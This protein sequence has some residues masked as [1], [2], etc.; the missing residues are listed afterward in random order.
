MRWFLNLIIAVS[1]FWS[2]DEQFGIGNDDT[3]QKNI[4]NSLQIFPGS[5]LETSS[6]NLDGIEVWKVLIENNDGAQIVF[7]W[8]KNYHL[9]Y[10]VVGNK[11]PF[12]YNLD[13]PLDVILFSTARF[14]AFES[15]STEAL[16][17]WKL[18][19]DKSFNNELVYQFILKDNSEP[20]TLKASSG[21]RL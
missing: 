13:L 16:K 11:G 18:F 19:R 21:D 1:L 14:L 9:L 5:V 10:Q 7:Y 4:D 3:P 12:N 20:I 17:S 15:H 6:V 2:C 8:Q